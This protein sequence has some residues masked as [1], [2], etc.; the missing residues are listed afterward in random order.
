MEL[1]YKASNISEAHIVAGLLQTYEIDAHV[2][3]YYLQGG[4]GDLAAMDFATIYVADE[5]VEAARAVI[6]EYEKSNHQPEDP[7]QHKSDSFITPLVI[8]AASV[9][10]ILILAILANKY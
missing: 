7:G 9:L 1:I 8:I 6:E 4:V 5:D 2:G 3:G 10:M